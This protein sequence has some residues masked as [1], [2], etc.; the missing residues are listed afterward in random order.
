MSLL[1][2]TQPNVNSQKYSDS[3]SIKKS[4]TLKAITINGNGIPIGFSNEVTFNK[5]NKVI[6]PSWYATLL[7]GSN[8]DKNSFLS[9]KKALEVEIAGAVM[10]NIAENP[11]LI[12][13]TGGYVYGCYLKDIDPKK[14]KMWLNAGLNNDWVIQKINGKDIQNIGELQKNMQKYKG[15]KVTLIGVRD[16]KEKE[17]KVNF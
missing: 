16:Y 3:I 15:K 17:F 9:I 13:A 14:G 12:D 5:V 7:K 2:G 11:D 10:I 8:E 4:T 1:D 6:Y